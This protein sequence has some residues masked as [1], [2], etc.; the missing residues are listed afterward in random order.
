MVVSGCLQG[1]VVE[2]QELVCGESQLRVGA[3]LVIA[4]LDFKDAWSST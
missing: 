3:S 2:D 1:P 4:E